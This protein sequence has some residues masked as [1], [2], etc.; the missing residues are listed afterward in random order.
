MEDL[1]QS[2]MQGGEPQSSAES[3]GSDADPMAQLLQSLLGG[4]APQGFEPQAASA[5]AQGEMDLGSLLQGVLGGAGGL[6]G[7]AAQ[8]SNAD[9][10]GLGDVL[11]AM[12]GGGS[13]TTQSNGILDPI[14]AG[15]AEK[16]GLSPQVAQAVV[17][18]VLGKLMDRRLQG[19]MVTTKVPAQSQSARPQG[20]SIETVVQKM[21]SGKRVT[22]TEIRSAG[23]ARELAAQTGLNR[24]TAE[25]SLQEVLNALGGQ[26]TTGR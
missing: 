5:P 17:A 9:A 16:I 2:L 3:T 10:G 25:A 18:F 20:P 22:K 11:G 7:G 1:L 12:M 13:P 21:N 19:D 26:L 24:A 6:A 8:T 15:L 4:G 23:M 14:V